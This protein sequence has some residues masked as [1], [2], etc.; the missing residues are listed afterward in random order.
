LRKWVTGNP[1]CDP[2]L[3]RSLTTV[4]RQRV[5][6][7]AQRLRSS[8]HV[9][10]WAILRKRGA[11]GEETGS[12]PSVLFG[13]YAL[14]KIRQLVMGQAV[15]FVLNSAAPGLV[16]VDSLPWRSRMRICGL[17]KPG[18]RPSGMSDEAIRPVVE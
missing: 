9:G 5:A 3:Y 17:I 6:P 16:K 1:P 2:L 15:H 8:R 7:A 10:H 13:V 14:Q 11:A 18:Y 12:R 4:H